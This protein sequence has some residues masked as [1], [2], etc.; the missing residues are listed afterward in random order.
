MRQTTC[1][2][3]EGD[4]HSKRSAR[5][6]VTG[7][8]TRWTPPRTTV[9]ESC[10]FTGVAMARHAATVCFLSPLGLVEVE[11]ADAGVTRVRLGA[12]G[13][14]REVGDGEA[15]EHARKTRVEILEYLAG[16]LRQFTVPVVLGGTPFQKAVW[17]K[18]Q[19]IGYGKTRTYGEIAAELGKPRAARAVG[20]ACGANPV[21]ILVP[22][23]RIVS[24]NGGGGGFA[25]GIRMKHELLELERARAR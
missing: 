7:S 9:L 10:T 11:C 13:K 20:T 6:R 12:R 21:A 25:A 23:H 1:G 24:G 8:F 18:L 3:A 15:M 2:R 16:R 19:A 14:P 22:C 17:G 4:R 5:G